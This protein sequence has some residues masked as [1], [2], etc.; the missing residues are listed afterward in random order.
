MLMRFFTPFIP[1]IS[2]CDV[3][4]LNDATVV[5]PIIHNTIPSYQYFH[6]SLLNFYLLFYVFEDSLTAQKLKLKNVY[7]IEDNIKI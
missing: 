5:I 4:F 2:H 7:N 1:D 3:K 6:T